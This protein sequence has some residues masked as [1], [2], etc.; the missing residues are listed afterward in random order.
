MEYLTNLKTFTVIV[1]FIFLSIQIPLLSQTGL[2]PGPH[3][4]IYLNNNVINTL[5][6]RIT[7]NTPEWQSFQGY[8][9]YYSINTPWGSEIIDGIAS[10]ALAYLLTDNTSYADR[11]IYFM[12][13]W[14]NAINATN[15]FYVSENE[16]AQLFGAVGLGFDWLYNYPG[17]TQ[18]KKDSLILTMQKIY[19]YGQLPWDQGGGD[20]EVNSRDSDQLIGGA[21]TALNW[22]TATYGDNDSAVTMINRGR[23]IWNE[24]VQQWITNSIGGVW[25]EGSQY[26]YNTLPFL[27]YFTEAER[28]ANGIDYWNDNPVIKNF[29]PNSITALTWLTPPSNDHILTYNDQEDENSN[30]WNRRNHFTAIATSIAENLGFTAEAAKG[31]FWIREIC[32]NNIDPNIW[33]LFLWYGREKAHTDYF[34]QST[35][36]GYFCEGLD[37]MFLRSNWTNQTGY[38]TFNASWT[39]VDHQFSDGGHFNI[40]RNGDYL[41]RSVRHYD[42][43]FQI[44]GKY[45]SYDGEASNILLIESDFENDER[46]NAMGSPELFESLG[47]PQITKHRINESPLFAYSFADLGSSYN[48]PY[49][50]WGGN[51]SR[52]IFYTRQFVQVSPDFYFIYDRGRTNDPGWVKYILH[53][54]IEPT[55]AGNLVTQTSENGSQKLFQKTLYPETVTISKINEANVWNIAN[56]LLQDWMIPESERKWHVAIQPAISDSFNILNVIET[57]SGAGANINSAQLINSSDR[58]GAK[59]GDWVVVFT[60]NDSVITNTFTYQFNTE[61]IPIKNLVC[62]LETNKIYNINLNNNFLTSQ[63]TGADGTILFTI[64]TPPPTCNISF[65]KIGTSVN[66]DANIINEFKLFQNYP[67]PF[68]PTTKIRYSVP[69]VE[70]HRY[71]SQQNVLLKVYDVL[72]N[73]VATLVNE[74]KPAGNYEVEFKSSA[75]SLQ[76]ASGIYFYKLQAGSFYKV[77]KMILLR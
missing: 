6:S 49:D 74:E 44:N 52:V 8:L 3:P 56:G 31:R 70:T 2:P 7:A 19:T 5:K 21:N 36:A 62:D 41:T 35:P 46:I 67:N 16:Y 27:L 43:L 40:W 75:G 37:W 9:D 39:D 20:F 13:E 26:S 22:G 60:K 32:P 72:G 66:T 59:L 23:E 45:S 17:F 18:Q 58:L 42:F 69:S 25:S 76:L 61:N 33:K 57:S 51:S 73:E 64:N 29:I 11:A 54:R 53:S 12:D 65:E 71:A 47:E 10:F 50:P 1:L 30:Y 55:V 28:T 15:P 4:R 34:N 14:R 38:S 77:M 48:R 24:H 63:N 68:N